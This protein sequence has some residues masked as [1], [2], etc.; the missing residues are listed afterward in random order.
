MLHKQRYINIR[1]IF[2]SYFN[3]IRKV[4]SSFS[5]KSSPVRV[6]LFRADNTQKD[7]RTDVGSLVVS[8]CIYVENVPK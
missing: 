2:W 7:G 6:T 4:S 5:K 8:V 3:T 1:V